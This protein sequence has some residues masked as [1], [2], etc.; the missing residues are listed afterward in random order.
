MSSVKAH[1]GTIKLR[2]L[3]KYRVLLCATCG[4]CVLP[5]A[6]DRHLKCIHRLSRAE[7][8]PHVNTALKLKLA[9]GDHV[10]YPD[11]D[12]PPIAGLPIHDGYACSA[13]G[14]PHLCQTAKRMQAHWRADHY[15][16]TYARTVADLRCRPVKL[17]SFFK[18][19][20]LR[21]FIVANHNP[22]SL[23]PLSTLSN[24]SKA[25]LLRRSP[26]SN[27]NET[28]MDWMLTKEFGEHS[29]STL[30]PTKG[31][32]ASWRDQMLQ[33]GIVTD[34]LRYALLSMTAS[35]VAYEFPFS[36]Q[37]YSCEATKYRQM[38]IRSLA[39][40]S[41][42]INQDNFFAHWNFQRLMTMCCISRTQLTETESGGE[43]AVSSS[44]LPDYVRIQRQGR[45]LV[46]PPKGGMPTVSKA[47]HTPPLAVVPHMAD[48]H[49][50]LNPYDDRLR[51]LETIMAALTHTFVDESCLEA[52]RFLRRCWP[53][54]YTQESVSFRDM[55]LMFSARV[56]DRY[57]ELL[58]AH[59]PVAMVV[60][61]HLCVLWSLAEES[62]WYM[63]GHA[64]RMLFKIAQCLPGEWQ[65][66][67]KWPVE[68]ILGT[69]LIGSDG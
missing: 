46:W 10:V 45:A 51:D 3:R 33:V 69:N 59:D 52:V 41:P 44:V 13:D 15:D 35:H 53:M 55:A 25:S 63:R 20:S 23:S 62:Y 47:M 60:F 17:Q 49:F 66:W 12:N 8:K 16:G 61:A 65:E 64:A 9:N 43:L 31:T 39:S 40:W 34:F 57:F 11:A 37:T 48:P 68:M 32:R 7:R 28:P 38:A 29:F 6:L 18:G 1:P 27:P 58:D 22:D 67:I 5:H 21:Y 19:S 26:S 42:E 36:R 56:S 24:M 30:L 14:C 54:P 50:N 4:Y 2:H